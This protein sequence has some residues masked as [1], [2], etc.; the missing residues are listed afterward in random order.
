MA[1]AF[2]SALLASFACASDLA[3]KELL[4]EGYTVAD[5]HFHKLQQS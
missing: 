1:K 4:S 2:A 5:M 3:I